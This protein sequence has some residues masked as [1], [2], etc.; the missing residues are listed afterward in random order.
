MRCLQDTYPWYFASKVT[1]MQCELFCFS[2]CAVCL[3]NLKN[4]YL[5]VSSPS[6]V[7]AAELPGRE[8][9][10]LLHGSDSLLLPVTR[11]QP[12]VHHRGLCILY[13]DQCFLATPGMIGYLM[14]NMVAHNH[15]LPP[16][17]RTSLESNCHADNNT[18]YSYSICFWNNI[19][20]LQGAQE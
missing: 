4:I 10:L 5:F 11:L 1:W 14:M 15:F 13:S 3:H 7:W 17:G 12:Y 20:V 2:F 19:S 6:V 18:V 9:H 16:W 8:L